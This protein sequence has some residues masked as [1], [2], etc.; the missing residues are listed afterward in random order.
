VSLWDELEET[1]GVKV[2]VFTLEPDKVATWAQMLSGKGCIWT[3]GYVF[4]LDP[5]PVNKE[6]SYSI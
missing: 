2:P 6:E 3:S 5:I 1:R 4:K